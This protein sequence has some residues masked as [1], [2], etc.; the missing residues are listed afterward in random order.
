M[1]RAFYGPRGE[2]LPEGRSRHRRHRLTGA[3]VRRVKKRVHEIER[4]VR[5]RLRAERDRHDRASLGHCPLCRKSVGDAFPCSWV[6]LGRFAPRGAH[7]HLAR[8][9][10]PGD[11]R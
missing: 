1:T 6:V 9:V 5:A 8:P 10:L 11:G 3:Q 4:L 2:D 7:R